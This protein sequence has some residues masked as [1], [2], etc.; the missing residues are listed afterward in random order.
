MER[1]EQP[2]R[3]AETNGQGHLLVNHDVSNLIDGFFAVMC[4][5]RGAS[6][7]EALIPGAPIEI[8]T[9]AHPGRP[10]FAYHAIVPEQIPDD[11]KRDFL[12]AVQ[13]VA[14]SAELRQLLIAYDPDT[15]ARGLA[16]ISS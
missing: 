6:S 14:G 9:Q 12:R 10:R 8:D 16:R 2:L 1:Q 11:G 7:A 15:T 5:S 13:E 4:G 3:S